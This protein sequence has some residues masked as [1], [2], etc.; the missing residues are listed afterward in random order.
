MPDWDNGRH[1]GYVFTYTDLIADGH[2]RRFLDAAWQY[3][4]FAHLVG[5]LGLL[6]APH[7]I[8]AP[9]ISSA[10]VFGALLTVG[11]YGIG[12]RAF[13][14]ELAGLLAAVFGLY[15]PLILTSLHAMLVDFPLA[16]MVAV[17]V[18]LTLESRRF[19]RRKTSLLVGVAAGL[20]L[21]TKATFPLFVVPV[22]AVVWLRGGIRNWANVLLSA[23]VAVAVSLPW[24]WR[25]YE[26]V[27]G[28]TKGAVAGATG[29][30]GPGSVT[31]DRFTIEN[32]SWYFWNL[33]NSQMLVIFSALLIVGVGYYAVSAVRG[34]KLGS[35]VPELVVG[36]VA[37]YLL[38]T[39]LTLKDHRYTLPT[40]AFIAPLATGWIIYLGRRGRV[41]AISVL[42]AMALL[43]LG[44]AHLFKLD[45][46]IR[47]SLPGASNDNPSKAGHFTLVAN[48]HF[49]DGPPQ[50][51][52]MSDLIPALHRMGLDQIAFD[53]TYN[54]DS[55][56][57]N[58]S[59]LSAIA[60]AAGFQVVD[61]TQIGAFGDNGALVVRYRPGPAE[62]P[63]CLAMDD[64]SGVYI[65]LGAPATE[66]KDSRLICPRAY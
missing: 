39:L 23:L 1:I 32:F 7:S 53:T 10:V 63:P 41:A 52:E 9:V 51:S 58:A 21:L 47:V 37:S 16:A 57:Y 6:F 28:F 49:N 3:P 18:W 65:G 25:H 54:S 64:G 44:S 31:P 11:C 62:P 5:G 34:R 59:G 66:L 20:G 26:T 17:T 40:V 2:P 27:F 55:A 43:E 15:S 24:Y 60:I 61:R 33:L 29:G 12:R 42:V 4:P 56:D 48:D 14:S 46:P 30:G 36:L 45:S 38:V 19:E 22:M 8:D 50:H 13:N 35:Y